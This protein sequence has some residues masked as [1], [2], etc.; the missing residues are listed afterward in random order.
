M[1]HP[2]DCGRFVRIGLVDPFAAVILGANLKFPEI[3]SHK[4]ELDG[5]RLMD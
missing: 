5:A 4:S 3:S 2:L 1:V